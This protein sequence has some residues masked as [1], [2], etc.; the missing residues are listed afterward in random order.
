MVSIGRTGKA[1]PFAMLEPVIVGG[2][3]VS[4]ATLHNEDQVRIKD[5]RPGDTV[6]VRRAGD[7]I[8]EVRGPVLA[9]PAGG[10]G[11]VDLPDAVPG[12]RRAAGASRGRE[13]HLLRQRGVPGP[14]GAAHLPFR[15]L[16]GPWTSSTWASGRSGSSTEAGLLHDVAD[17]Y[18]LDYDK[19][20]A[21]EGWG[22]TSVA[23]LRPAIDASKSPASRQPAGRPVDPPPGLG[24]Q[25]DPRPPFPGPRPDHGRLCGGAGGGGGGRADHRR[26][27]A[28]LLRPPA[29]PRAGGAAAPGRAQLR[30]TGRPRL[31]RRS[32]PAMSVVVTGT[33][34]GWS[35]EEAEDAIKARGGKSP[36]SVSKKTTAVVVGAEPGAAKLAKAAELGVPVLDEAG[37][38][39]LLETGEVSRPG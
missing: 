17:I 30:G 20:A 18:D 37:F 6:V 33:L 13:R 10:P 16:V 21:F 29:Q 22:E 14:A 5:V 25:P 27:R 8:P 2:A 35:R 23:N 7:V 26:Q 11:A 3:K 31:S 28:A 38:A 12:V 36:G 32:W 39:R 24:R 34:E 15:R 1:T 19:I 9:A 4:L